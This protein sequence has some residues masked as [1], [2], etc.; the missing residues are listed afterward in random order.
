VVNC[1]LLISGFFC[2]NAPKF[3][4]G[5]GLGDSSRGMGMCVGGTT[6]FFSLVFAN[7]LDVACCISTL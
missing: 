4:E 6:I 2:S 7:H 5:L 1:L 3:N